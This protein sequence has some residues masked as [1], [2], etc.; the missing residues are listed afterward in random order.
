MLAAFGI[1]T[2]DKTVEMMPTIVFGQ[3]LFV[4]SLKAV[5]PIRERTSAGL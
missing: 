5:A 3:L 2:P 1:F 4:K